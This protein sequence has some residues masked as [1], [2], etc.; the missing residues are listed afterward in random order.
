M[1]VKWTREQEQVIRLRG[2]NLLVSAA[3]GSG[4]TAVLVERILSRVMD[5]QQPIDVDEL[6]IVTFTRAAAG[7]MRERIGQ[8]LQRAIEEDPDNDHLQRQQTLLHHAQ[9]NTI[10][11]F[12]SYVIQNYFQM[13]DLDPAYRM[14]EDGEIRLLRSDVVKEVLEE[15]YTEQ[16]PEF[17]NFIECYAAGK[18][19]E[20]IEDLIL[21]LFDF[22]SSYP[23]PE[24][25]LAKCQE[26]YE[27]S[28]KEELEDSP[29]MRYLMGE[30]E[31]N[32]E[33]IRRMQEETLAV[34]SRPGAPAL[35]EPMLQ[36][37]LNQTQA[38]QNCRT[39]GE[40]QQAFASLAFPM[41]SRKKDPD[42][43]ETLKETEGE[44]GGDEEAA[45]R[46]SGTVFFQDGGRNPG[47]YGGEPGTGERTDPPDHAVYGIVRRKEAEKESSGLFGSGAFCAEDPSEKGGRALDPHRCRE[48]AGAAVP[49]DHDRRVS[50]Q[51]LYSGGAAV[52]GV[53]GRGRDLEPVYGRRYQAEY[54]RLPPGAAGAV[55]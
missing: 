30:T 42:A 55:S 39:Y 21:N 29:W 33:S 32:L 53:R 20:G 50:G 14:A 28:T 41:L 47:R 8:A 3:A 11:G 4:K 25:W 1:G 19:D 15:G 12:C 9:I 24:E 34:L 40:L 49:G 23:W 31:K 51:Q 5:P 10:H 6:L 38:L 22:A 35:Y 44:A 26:T 16:T 43:D 36:A 45:E 27:I 46:S 18:T 54:L 48:R 37:D 2:K 13:I 52:G 17:E 7:E